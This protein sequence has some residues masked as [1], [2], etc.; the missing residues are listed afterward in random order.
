M[1]NNDVPPQHLS[2]PRFQILAL[3]G[4]GY[5]G[6][7]TAKILAEL[8]QR[9]GKPLAELFDLIAGTSVGAII[10]AGLALK[11][12]A[13]NIAKSFE[14]QGSH[15][16]TPRLFGSFARIFFTKYKQIPLSQSITQIL[17][18]DNVTTSLRSLDAPL[19]ITAVSHTFA[20][21]VSMTSRGFSNTR[22][23]D[24][25]LLDAILSSSAAPTYFPPH[26]TS[27]EIFVDGG[28]VANAP[29]LL[30]VTQCLAIKG[31]D[32]KNLHVL[33]IGTVGC[34]EK[35]S[36]KKI[37]TP[38]L[39]SWVLR[40]GLFQLTQAVQETMAVEQCGVLLGDHYYRLDHLPNKVEAKAIGLD[41]VTPEASKILSSLAKETVSK[42]FLNDKF[43]LQGFLAHKP[44]L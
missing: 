19:L 22:A 26:S 18:A 27:K 40:R 35:K 44:S 29:E 24:I 37:G 10:A 1:L 9:A 28:L 21:H 11:I 23:T 20:K 5:R 3:S 33:S 12:P 34:S 43:L 8:E 36:T 7:Y 38:G 15:I 31:V 4:G 6:L 32:I 30:A 16:F 13:V 39:V 2:T 14:E 42:A 17:G 41:V 25:P